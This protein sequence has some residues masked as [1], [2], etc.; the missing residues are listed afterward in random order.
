MIYIFYER[1]HVKHRRFYKEILLQRNRINL[2]YREKG[3]IGHLL[4]F[5]LTI[6]PNEMCEGVL[7]EFSISR[8]C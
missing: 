6:S 5:S 8:E 2:A 1:H 3:I 4:F 7:E